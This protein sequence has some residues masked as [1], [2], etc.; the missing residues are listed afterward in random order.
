[1]P[2][3]RIRAQ[4]RT[5][6]EEVG[7]RNEDPFEVDACIN[8]DG[9]IAPHGRMYGA[10]GNHRND[11]F[12]PFMMNNKGVIDFG[13]ADGTR[14]ARTDLLTKQMV[15]GKEFSYRNG[16]GPIDESNPEAVLQ[17]TH[18]NDL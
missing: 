12:Y 4:I 11:E 3:V 15:I 14:G 1:M 16:P 2:Y 13:Y 17:I 7:F 8:N 18:I 6:A 10:F 5:G 9:R